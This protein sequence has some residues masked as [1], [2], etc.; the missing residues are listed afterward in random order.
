MN[1][2]VTAILSATIWTQAQ[3]PVDLSL[4]S[5]SFSSV[6]LGDGQDIK[7]DI[8]VF[9]ESKREASGV[10][11]TA[12]LPAGVNFSSVTPSQGECNFADNRITCNLG[13][14]GREGQQ[15]FDSVS[16]LS[17]YVKPTEVGTVALTAQITANEP[18]PNLS[19]NMKTTNPSATVN[20]PK[21]RKRVRFF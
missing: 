21:S 3:S 6:R 19:N 7:I 16:G 17:I 11:V 10:I 8:A 20:P 9:I 15:A 13:I 14:V 1:L 18:D 4:R 5:Y 12:D 2:I